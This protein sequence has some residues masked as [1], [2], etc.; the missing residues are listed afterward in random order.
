MKKDK[1]D[2]KDKEQ[3]KKIKKERSEFEKKLLQEKVAII[4]LVITFVICFA[5]FLT[6]L[7]YTNWHYGTLMIK[8]M[9]SE[10][11]YYDQF[12]NEFVLNKDKINNS[13][14]KPLKYSFLDFDE[15][16]YK[17]VVAYIAN[18]V[19]HNYY[20]I[21]R[22]NFDNRKVYGYLIDGKD[23]HGLRKDGS[24]ATDGSDGFFKYYDITFEGNTIIYKDL[25]LCNYETETYK[26][27]GDGVYWDMFDKFVKEWMQKDTADWEYDLLQ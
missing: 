10:I 2:I 14:Y 1:K 17:E 9:K 25:A 5:G 27:Y 26:V 4:A 24:V 15:D 7:Y 22:F 16:G 21:F 20:I 18:D 3:V 19:G 13:L 23:F 6:Y 12:E 11:P 8:A